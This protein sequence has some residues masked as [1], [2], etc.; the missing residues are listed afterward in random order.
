[1]TAET[2]NFQLVPPHVHCCNAA[3]WAIQTFKNHFIA[4]LCSTDNKFPIHLW[5][6]LLPQAELTLNLLRGSCINPCLSAWAQLHGPIDF[7][8]TPIVPPGIHVI[9]H[10][11][12]TT[13]RSWAPHSVDRWYL[14]PA[15][16]SYQCYTVWIN[17]T[18]AQH[19][20]DTLTWLPTKIHMPS[21]SSIDHIL[22][23][24]AN[25]AHASNIRHQTH[26]WPH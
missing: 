6:R 16:K 2:I 14:S 15:L 24:I 3:K 11:K 18:R 5:D 20:C 17:K 9:V 1:M 7:N 26:H 13:Q 22:A 10:E 8:R 25:I 21:A 23:G 12:P 4:G 19:I